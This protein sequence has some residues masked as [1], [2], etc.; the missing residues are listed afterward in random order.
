MSEMSNNK[1]LIRNYA[2]LLQVTITLFHKVLVRWHTG[3][4]SIDNQHTRNLKRSKNSNL[5]R[6]RVHPAAQQDLRAALPPKEN[7]HFLHEFHEED[8]RSLNLPPLLSYRCR[9]DIHAMLRPI[10]IAILLG[11][12]Q[13][14]LMCSNI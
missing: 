13:V 14:S 11:R 7:C 2:Q 8:F 5:L 10:D 12:L 9:L 3:V 1:H 6:K 4:L